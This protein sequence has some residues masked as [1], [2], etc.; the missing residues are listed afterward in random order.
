M[1]GEVQVYLHAGAHR[2]GTS[3]FQMCLDQ[4]ATLLH[5]A[6]Y[7]LAYPGRDGI[8][9]GKL[10]MK[11]PSPRHGA[12]KAEK[13]LS[14]VRDEIERLRSGR[15]RLV[16]SDE[17]IPGRMIHFMDSLF[18]P[19]RE[20]R[21]RVLRQALPGPVAHLMLVVRSYDY[22]FTSAYRMRTEEHEQWPFDIVRPAFQKMNEG[23]PELVEVLRAELHPEKMTVVTYD[24]RGESRELLTRL[25]PDID[26]KALVEP[27]RRMNRT[28]TDAALMEIQWRLHAGL[29]PD[30][31]EIASIIARHAGQG[32]DLG[33]T[34]FPDEE[35]AALHDRYAADL[36]R[37]RAMPG[38]TL[39]D[40]NT[41]AAD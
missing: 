41:E 17:N 31:A 35:R 14:D 20:M 34:R 38:L 16:L 3:S 2:T 10:K 33:V 25:L 7:D 40:S 22:L 6:G 15:S 39:I 24:A 29:K 26:P 27:K 13:F 19:A 8:P 4:N 18:Y 23:W 30:K 9:G 5:E 32:A 1:A 37:L 12:K 36:D 21:A 28:A 11:L